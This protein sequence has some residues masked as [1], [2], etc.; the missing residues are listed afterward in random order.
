MN[1]SK[2]LTFNQYSKHIRENSKKV[3]KIKQGKFYTYYYNFKTSYKDQ[4]LKYFDYFPLVYIT[5][6]TLSSNSNFT[7]INFHHLPVKIRKDLLEGIVEYDR[8]LN[9]EML[10]IIN[11]Y[12][13]KAIRKY[14]I[15]SVDMLYEVSSDKIDEFIELST[16]TYEGVSFKQRMV[17]FH[18]NKYK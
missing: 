15:D 4:I 11:V 8:P 13:P 14:I 3:S 9:Y 6:I 5:D 10:K 1:Q 16:N 12:S 17:H 2:T 7:A 18:R